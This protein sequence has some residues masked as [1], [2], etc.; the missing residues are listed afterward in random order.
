[1]ASLAIS[2]V[3]TGFNERKTFYDQI[4]EL[5][6]QHKIFMSDRRCYKVY[7]HSPF[8][9]HHCL[10]LADKK[11]YCEHVTLEL[12]LTDMTDSEGQ[13]V[14]PKSQ[15]YSG[16]LDSL[17]YK[18]EIFCSLEH[19]CETAYRVL[20]DMGAYNLAF[21]NCQHFCNKLLEELQLPGHTTD[22]EKIGW[23]AAVVGVTAA[24]AGTLIAINKFKRKNN[25]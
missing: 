15:L 6:S 8:V 2:S 7:V 12:T 23:G 22:T 18:G 17:V 1:M 19:V 4:M 24:V 16:R 14:A 20:V 3:S 25:N 5:N 13:Q 21:N 11:G 9:D 10:V